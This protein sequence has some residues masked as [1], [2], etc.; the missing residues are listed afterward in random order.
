MKDEDGQRRTQAHNYVAAPSAII[1]VSLTID[2]PTFIY[3]YIIKKN[4][5]ESRTIEIIA[6]IL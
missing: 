1:Y 5:N 4:A 2:R 6:Y 3:V